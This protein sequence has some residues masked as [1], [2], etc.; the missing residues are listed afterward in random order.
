MCFCGSNS[1]SG[2]EPQKPKITTHGCRNPRSNTVRVHH[3]VSL[4]LS[5]AEYWFGLIDGH[6]G[7]LVPAY[8]RQEL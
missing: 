3:R 7:G 6:Y 2:L 1:S 5:T 8:W 4:H